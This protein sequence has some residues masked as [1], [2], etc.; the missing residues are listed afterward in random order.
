MQ[1][2]QAKSGGISE[3]LSSASP[4]ASLIDAISGMKVSATDH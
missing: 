3:F 2:L 4:T 1:M